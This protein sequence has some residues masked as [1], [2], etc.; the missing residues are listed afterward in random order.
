MAHLQC[1]SLD[2]TTLWPHI[3]GLLPIISCLRGVYY[4]N[5]TSKQDLLSVWNHWVTRQVS[6][7]K[8]HKVSGT[9]P[10]WIFMRFLLKFD[11]SILPDGEI[12][13][14]QRNVFLFDED[15]S[16]SLICNCWLSSLQSQ[17]SSHNVLDTTRLTELIGLKQERFLKLF[18]QTSNH[19]F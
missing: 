18:I 19:W 8:F 17:N 12:S 15:Q 10:V 5:S 6:T 14:T 3:V 9:G 2:Q 4:F 16:W 11:F 7:D 1:F 13:C